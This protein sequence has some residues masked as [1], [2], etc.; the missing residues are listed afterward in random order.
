VNGTTRSNSLADATSIADLVRRARAIADAAEQPLRFFA[1][2][3]GEASE[4]EPPSQGRAPSALLA[5]AARA[6]REGE[7]LGAGYLLTA[8]SDVVL[9]LPVSL[10][11]ST[12]GLLLRDAITLALRGEL[13]APIAGDSLDALSTGEIDVAWAAA[14]ERVVCKSRS[15]R[16][17]LSLLLRVAKSDVP[18]MLSGESGTGKEV[19]ARTLHLASLRAAGPFVAVNCAAI[20]ATLF[21]AELFGYR[22]GAFTGAVR[23][24]AGHAKSAHG[25]TLLLDELGELSP[26]AQA[27]LLRFLEERQVQAIGN[28]HPETVDVRVVSATNRDL[29]EEVAEGRFREDLYYRLNVVEIALPPL[30]Q[31]RDDI[32]SLTRHL[33]ERHGADPDSSSSDALALLHRYSWPGNVRELDNELRRARALA[34]G[35]RIEPRH[36]SRKLRD[37]PAPPSAGYADQL[38]G[39][40][41]R[42]VTQALDA[43]QGNQSAAARQ[44]GISRQHLRQLM[45]KLD[46]RR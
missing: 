25:G 42:L 38:R 8:L 21:E 17:A 46:I 37:A 18:V 5:L 27:K 2:R 16:R 20:P 29:A 36:L 31:R 13:G 40:K 41:R 43:C 39:F 34:G 28:D 44:L 30:R 19:F 6:A 32:E 15:M 22:R 7:L 11:T 45:T 35:A 1:V 33:L 10:A 9:A 12:N 3:A 26:D 4:L 23:D 14:L 24:H